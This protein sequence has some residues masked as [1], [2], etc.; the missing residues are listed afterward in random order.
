MRVGLRVGF[1]G[2]RESS[3][4]TSARKEALRL[5]LASF[6][7]MVR[8]LHH[9]DC[10]GADAIAHAIAIELGWGVI[11]HPP[12]SDSHRAFCEGA[13]L[14]WPPRPYMQRND[15]IIS[16]VRHL[17]AMPTDPEQEILRSGTWATVRHARKA[18]LKVTIL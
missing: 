16:N 8:F 13:W 12:L 1:T 7:D 3:A 4:I 5:T 11:V 15:A 6:K 17:I 14:V 10:I 18:G 9:G 2:T